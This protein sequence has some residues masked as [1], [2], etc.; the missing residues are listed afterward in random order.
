MLNPSHFY[1]NGNVMWSL[2]EDDELYFN[3]GGGKD[4]TLKS[5]QN[6]GFIHYPTIADPKFKDPLNFDF[7]LAED[8]PAFATNFE[9]WDY[10]VAGTVKGTII[11][12]NRAGGETAYNAEARLQ[13]DTEFNHNTI[14]GLFQYILLA[15]GILLILAWIV[16][17][18]IKGKKTY[19]ISLGAVILSLPCFVVVYFTYL[20]W[21]EILYFSFVF[22]LGALAS[23]IPTCV[24]YEKGKA[25][26]SIILCF[27][28]NFILSSGL[29]LGL[30]GIMNMLLT[31]GSPEV[32]SIACAAMLIYMIVNT[33]RFTKIFKK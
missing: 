32:I 22:L 13:P 4:Y 14:H 11:G 8:S 1:D 2:T 5:A 27:V 23:S 30:A 15:I 20:E 18:I 25:K 17:G 9:A 29:F 7:T 12:L 21:I 19:T 31:S 28:I 10:S 3:A 33:I 26:K 16:I 6:A 24:A